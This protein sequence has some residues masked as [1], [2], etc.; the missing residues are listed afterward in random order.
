MISESSGP[1]LHQG[2]AQAPSAEPSVV[3]I[4]LY[5]LIYFLLRI[6]LK[7]FSELEIAVPNA[8]AAEFH[9][10]GITYQELR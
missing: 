2:L 9:M 10:T 3:Q 5:N 8:G 6:R 1:L 4:R 7:F